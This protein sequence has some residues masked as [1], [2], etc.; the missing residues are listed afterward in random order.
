MKR[1]ILLIMVLEVACLVGGTALAAT[2][3]VPSDQPT[4]QD[5]IDAAGEGDT[6]LV[7]NGI[8]KGAGNRGLRFKSK[9]IEVRSENGP[10]YTIIDAENKT[11][12]FDIQ[13]GEGRLTVVDGF[14]ITGSASQASGISCNKGEF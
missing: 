2:I 1:L 12:V 7:A 4:I 9:I 8:Y 14:T 11:H 10:E 6:V 3:H 13:D 5:G